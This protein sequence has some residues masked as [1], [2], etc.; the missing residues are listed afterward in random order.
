MSLLNN[1]FE[2]TDELSETPFLMEWFPDNIG[3]MALDAGLIY[4]AT[5]GLKQRIDKIKKDKEEIKDTRQQMKEELIDKDMRA[6]IRKII[7]DHE[8]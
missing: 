2:T 1:F 8:E 4:L 7:R 6:R 5:N 3:E